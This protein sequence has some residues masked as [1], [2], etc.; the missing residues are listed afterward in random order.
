LR[1]P[2]RHRT[3]P[4][5][6]PR[7]LHPQAKQD[8]RDPAHADPANPDKMRVLCRRKHAVQ[9]I[10]LAFG[11]QALIQASQPALTTR[12]TAACQMQS[13]GSLPAEFAGSLHELG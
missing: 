13:H 9:T 3:P 2:V 6:R 7:H 10:R 5:V 4:Q 8:L 11:A 12:E 1:Q